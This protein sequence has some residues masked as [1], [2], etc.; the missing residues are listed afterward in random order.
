MFLAMRDGFADFG[1]T[2]LPSCRC[3]R[4]TTWARLTPS[5][6][7]M[8]PSVGLPRIPPRA[9]GDQASVTMPLAS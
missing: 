6:A 1:I 4:I 5:F 2:T 7:A 3:Q 8:S 9:N